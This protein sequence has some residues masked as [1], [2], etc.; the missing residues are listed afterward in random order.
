M[1]LDMKSGSST[2]KFDSNV[3]NTANDHLL[4]LPNKSVYISFD[5]HNTSVS[6][7]HSAGEEG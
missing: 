4:K 5:P 3:A 2:G 6:S 1:N 7:P